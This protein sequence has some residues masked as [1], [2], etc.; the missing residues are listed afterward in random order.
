MPLLPVVNA[1]K[2]VALGL[3]GVGAAGQA[4]LSLAGSEVVGNDASLVGALA[5]GGGAALAVQLASTNLTGN[6]LL[7]VGQGRRGCQA[8]CRGCGTVGR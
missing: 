3:V 4:S 6:S 5:V 2:L 1:N 8:P 7:Q